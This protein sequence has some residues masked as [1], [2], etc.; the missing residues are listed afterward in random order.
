MNWRLKKESEKGEL[1]AQH[2][3]VIQ[4]IQGERER[5]VTRAGGSNSAVG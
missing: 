2:E 4:T 1:K 3:K 5:G